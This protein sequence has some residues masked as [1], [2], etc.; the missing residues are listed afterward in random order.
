MSDY[1]RE[2]RLFLIRNGIHFASQKGHYDRFYG[3]YNY[4]VTITDPVSV[5]LF[6]NYQEKNYFGAA[7]LVDFKICEPGKDPVWY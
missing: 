2:I 7:K 6:R 1:W 4:I 5:T 3:R